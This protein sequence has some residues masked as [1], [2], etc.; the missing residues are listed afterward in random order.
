MLV[1]LLVS[2]EFTFFDAID[3]HIKI[4]HRVAAAGPTSLRSLREL[5]L[6]KPA[7]DLSERRERRLPRQSPKGEGGRELRLGKPS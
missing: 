3:F 5:R 7:R 6:G 1:F 4:V 2:S